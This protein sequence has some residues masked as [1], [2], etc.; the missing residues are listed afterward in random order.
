MANREGL[1]G[2]RLHLLPWALAV[3]LV[4]A[5]TLAFAQKAPVTGGT[6]GKTLAPKTTGASWKSVDDLVSQQKYEAA[7]AM[8]EKILAEAKTAGDGVQ[9]TKALV[10]LTQLRMGL[11][12]YETAV[13]RLREEPW[14]KD[15]LDHA[16]L[17][18]FYA[19][20]IVTYC[21]SYSWEIG[22]RE[23]VEGKGPVDLKAWTKDQLFAEAQKAYLRVWEQRS[24]LGSRPVSVLKEYIRPNDYPPGVRD[25]LRDAVSYLFVELLSD[26][27]FWTPQQSNDLFR[28]DVK[29]LLASG[30]SGQAADAV[31]ADP[32]AHPLQKIVA[33]LGDLEV[34]HASQGK[35]E[36]Q[37]EARLERLRRLQASLTEEEDRKAILGDLEDR[38][39]T[40]KGVPWYAMGKAE[41]AEFIQAMDR[42]DAFVL[43]RA[44]ALEGK[45]AYPASVG[46]QRCAHIVAS[47]EA[48]DFAIAGMSLD[49]A[50]RRSFAVTHK[51]LPAVY[52]R[53]YPVDLLQ[54]I[55]SSR[56]YNLLPQWREVKDLMAA[57][58]PAASWKLDLPET[59]DYRDH[60]TF[61]DPPALPKGAYVVA[62]SAREDFKESKNRILA[63]HFTVSGLVLLTRQEED[64][65]VEVTV[66]SG[67][68]GRPVA[69]AEVSLYQFDWQQGHH[70]VDAEKSGADGTVQFA[71]GP[72][73][74]NKSFFTLARK[75]DDLSLDTTYLGFYERTPPS[76]TVATLF[77]TDRSIYRPGQKLYWKVLVYRGISGQ[78]PTG[79]L[80][81]HARHRDP[82]RRQ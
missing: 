60:R 43:A 72:N 77:Y 65:D 71:S 12:G 76:E 63:V 59:P 38:I 39:G 4:L 11:H 74:R 68:D 41:Q 9:W 21:Q 19:H 48:P 1:S 23:K 61:V 45:K 5:L 20:A 32:K 62:V 75:G 80:P 35:S 42:P 3:L 10:R 37:L 47:I 18:L 73:L 81:K 70:K 44:V 56:D 46:G 26:T 79:L 50:G 24:A 52:F 31:L 14:P 58:K 7:A 33:V 36:A 82:A 2:R 69:G 17:D 28:L 78:G 67:D 55:A 16:T 53:A 51:N 40:F 8:A 15:P 49:G 30:P 13:R 57:T 25:T 66:L 29:S 22:Q 27:G 54:R 64:G 6:G 34:W